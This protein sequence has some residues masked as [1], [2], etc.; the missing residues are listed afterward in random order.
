MKSLLKIT[1]LFLVLVL[2]SSL[3]IACSGKKD[4]NA[5]PDKVPIGGDG[6]FTVPQ[7]N[8][9]D[10]TIF[11]EG[12]YKYALYDDG[13]AIIVE[14][15]GDELEIVV[16]DML[17]GYPVTA[18]ASG[19]FYGNMNATS[20]TM[21]NNLQ[22]IGSD[23]FN[24]CSQLTKVVIPET[25]WAIYPNAF[26][27]TP[28][29]NSLTDEFVIVGD[30]LL[31]KYNGTDTTVVLPDTIKHTSAVFM[32]SETIKD[33]TIPDSVY[34]IGCAMFSSSSISRVQ[35][36]NNVVLIDDS[37]FAYCYN[38]NYVN[39]PESLKTI[40]A[41]A[42][43]SCTSLNYIKV[44]KNVEKIAEYAFFRS[45]RFSHIYLPK[46]IKILGDHAF[47]DCN[48]L[49]YVYYEG[50]E[51]EFAALNVSGNNAPLSDAKKFYNYDYS[52]GIYEVKQ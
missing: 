1:S 6:K 22:V 46:S 4:P 37:A 24:G 44:G 9:S 10:E 40:E 36:G 51:E 30:S 34:T 38:L 14:H 41:Y 45:S 25:V 32:G 21:G 52:G 20:V 29:Y 23:A 35:I 11:T 12:V 47:T 19:A 26:T 28:W 2:V 33:V 5:S 43:S 31:L 49:S 15:T 8:I 27:D 42:F 17:G 48:Y 39:M 7:K 50:T 16:P 13:S 18:I 3:L